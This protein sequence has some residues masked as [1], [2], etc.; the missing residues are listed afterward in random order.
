MNSGTGPGSHSGNSLSNELFGA[1]ENPSSD[2]D[3]V[4]KDAR[5][6][7]VRV[8]LPYLEVLIWVCIAFADFWCKTWIS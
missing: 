8:N 6:R 7:Y 2:A 1:S 5:G 4:E 3:Y